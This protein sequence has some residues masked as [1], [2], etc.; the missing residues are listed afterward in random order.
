MGNGEMKKIF[1]LAAIVFI[2]TLSLLIQVPP[3]GIA[4]MAENYGHGARAIGMGG[5]FVG[6][7]DDFS[8]TFYNPAGLAQISGHRAIFGYHLGLPSLHIE[9]INGAEEH[10]VDDKLHAPYI[11]LVADLT[12]GLDLGRRLVFGLAGAF[13]GNFKSAYK[14]RYGTDFDPY[15]PIF[16]DGHEDQRIC[17]WFGPAVEV[18]P[19]LFA[20][21]G[22][23]FIVHG[24]DVE[25][26]VAVDALTGE[27][28]EERTRASMHVSTEIAP[29]AGVLLK[30]HDRISIGAV[31]R[32]EVAFEAPQQRATMSAIFPMGVEVPV[33]IVLPIHAHYTPAQY[34]LGLSWRPLDRLLIAADVTYTDWS[35]YTLNDGTQLDPP[36][37]DR[38]VPRIGTELEVAEGLGV[39]A[40][41]AYL[42]S[43]LPRQRP[44]FAVNLVD[45]TRHIF[46]LGSGYAIEWPDLFSHPLGIEA[47]VQVQY[48][49][50]RNFP[51]VNPGGPD[52]QSHGTVVAIGIQL[53]LRF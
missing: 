37:R 15:F 19:W 4:S 42:A 38:W 3:S 10:E 27:V 30:P 21:G 23:A 34:A 31:W 26:E 43:P 1:P 17:L 13:P 5:A 18:F 12:R 6:L 36:M 25:I 16:G 32:K 28:V 40:G 44:G 52:L 22:C 2:G 53:D 14:A 48:L 8:A 33:E 7:A 35:G 45:S 41:Y 50:P 49:E 29:L 11:A 24:E 46:S 39:R 20:G 51:N 9:E 47:F